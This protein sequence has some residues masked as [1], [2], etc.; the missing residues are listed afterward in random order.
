MVENQVINLAQRIS[1][2]RA[3]KKDQKANPAK[4]TIVDRFAEDVKITTIFRQLSDMQLARV[5]REYVVN[6]ENDALSRIVLVEVS[7]RLNRAKGGPFT[8]ADEDAALADGPTC[9]CG[10]EMMFKAAL[11]PEEVDYYEC[12]ST[13]CL[14]K[15]TIT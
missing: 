9:E 6:E 13:K 5:V 12:A 15:R 3:M 10:E 2:Y 8:E 4:Y 1:A 7:D 14:K 11:P